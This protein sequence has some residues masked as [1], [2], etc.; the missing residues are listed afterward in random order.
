MTLPDERTLPTITNRS[1]RPVGRNNHLSRTDRGPRL[2]QRPV[3]PHLFV[4]PTHSTASTDHCLAAQPPLLRGVCDKRQCPATTSQ[5][6]PCHLDGVMPGRPGLGRITSIDETCSRG[7][8]EDREGPSH[9]NS[10]SRTSSTPADWRC[11]QSNGN[12]APFVQAPWAGLSEPRHPS[13]A[14]TLVPCPFAPLSL[15]SLVS[16]LPCFLAP[17]FPC[18]LV[19]LPFPSS[20]LS[21]K[22]RSDRGPAP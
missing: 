2:A 4:Y 15:R 3:I 7:D 17:L 6:P 21:T 1:D 9:P 8:T 22:P 10:R 19:S 18:S 20:R 11:S 5:A 16:L 14:L 13:F 12:A